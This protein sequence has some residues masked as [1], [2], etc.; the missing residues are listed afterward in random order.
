MKIVII[1]Y[2]NLAE[3]LEGF[4]NLILSTRSAADTSTSKKLCPGKFIHWAVKEEMS[5]IFNVTTITFLTGSIFLIKPGV[6]TG[7]NS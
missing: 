3:E 4:I 7:L 6:S 2:K 5:Y 1:L